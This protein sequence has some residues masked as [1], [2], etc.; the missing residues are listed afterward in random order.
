ML[1]VLSSLRR[2]A[3]MQ[4][5]EKRGCVWIVLA[6]G[7]LGNVS[8][9][10][11]PFTVVQATR[12]RAADITGNG[13]TLVLAAGN[14]GLWAVDADDPGSA[15]RRVGS[16]KATPLQVA[17]SR[18]QRP[19]VLTVART[20]RDTRLTSTDLES[21]KQEELP[22]RGSSGV[23]VLGRDAYVGLDDRATGAGRVARLR[24]GRA[25]PVS[26]D[27]PAVA[28]IGSARD[29]LLAC[30]PAIGAVS[31]IDPA[32]GTVTTGSVA[33]L[34][35]TL[36]AAQGLADGRILVLTSEVLAVADS[37]T[38]F[39]QRPF[40]VPPSGPLFVG[41]WTP[42]RFSLAGTGLGPDDVRLEVPDGPDAGLVSSA[43]ADQTSDPEPLLVAGGAVGRYPL[44]LVEAASGN[45]VADTAFEVTDHWYDEDTGPSR[46]ITGATAMEGGGGWGGGP[47][48]PQ[49][50]GDLTHTGTWNTLV[51]LVDT[52]TA[53][54]PTTPAATVTANQTTVLGHVVDG[55]TFNSQT[56]SA[57]HYYEENSGFVAASGGNPGRG[58]TIAARNNQVFGPVG[59]PD[60]WTTYFAQKKD[61]D[62][63]VI[64]ARWSS[65][66]TTIQTIISQALS[67][68]V[69][70]RADLTAVD[71]LII[72]PRSPD[73]DSA[74]GD[75]FV[76]PHASL[77]K[78]RLLLGTNVMTEQGDI[79]Y[80][81]VPL[82][83]AA[84]DGRQMHTTLSHEVGHNLGLLDVYDIEEYSADVT[85]RIT[86]DWEMMAGSR[87]RLPH[88]SLSNKMRMG[89]VPADQLRLYNFQGSGGVNDTITLHPAERADP[90]AGRVRGIE[91]RLG[92]GLNY[93]VEYRSEQSGLISDD[94]VTDRRVVVTDVTSEDY[95]APLA[96]PRIMFVAKDVDNDG[97]I[98][99]TG[100]DFED[101]DPGTQ[102]DLAVT[103]V[104]TAVDQ[105]SVRVTYGSQGKPEP[106]IRPWQGGPGWQSP[107]IEVRNDRATAEPA[108]W[109]NTPWLGHD[110]TIVAKVR[111][112]GDLIATGVVVDFFV[113]EY[114]TGDGP[115]VSLGF[116]RKDV[117]P[118][119]TVEFSRPWNPSSA[120]GRHYCVI[121]RIRL[122]QAP[123][124][125]AIV[126]QNIY[127]NEARSN[128]TSFISASASPST[129]VGTSVLL[130]NPFSRSTHVFAEV[131]QTHPQH[132]VFLEHQWLRVEGKGLRPVVVFDEAVWGTPEW[133]YVGEPGEKRP[134]FL[135]E[136]P[137]RV[138]IEGH[139]VRPYQTDCGS[140]IL[141]GGVGIQ[142]GAG[143]MTAV[144]IERRKLTYTTGFVRF[145]DDGS[146]VTSGTVL[147]EVSDG[148][149]SVTFDTPVGQDGRFGRD[150]DNPFGERTKWVQAHFLGTYSAAAS[151]SEQLE[152]ER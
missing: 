82:E 12:I 26:P 100:A 97:P 59:L 25:R 32:T 120:D 53:R 81:Y 118:G 34:P 94:L 11:G 54:W 24:A 105:A 16:V 99:G 129:R 93:Y 75:R 144:E 6:G 37:V 10:G 31:A 104:S 108:K 116:D 27:L 136:V 121:V 95:V 102:M 115:W 38:D 113:T 35:G 128:Y 143:R 52:S 70:T 107:D 148:Q 40:I 80:T 106:G 60:P 74:A 33:D 55:I 135:W 23:L 114:T 152:P 72:V 41:S 149:R 78:R 132:R 4:V 36:I 1:S 19:V 140:R 76:W 112:A 90:P 98:I 47:N 91:I 125:P 13:S 83:F 101:K 141:T 110:N 28:R 2:P 109:F 22:V 85:A 62:G 84:H 3:G 138:S 127:N 142:V 49:N 103:V 50:L 122:Y 117:G 63:N 30:H 119:A 17:A 137:N 7:A 48:T 18:R 58:L 123:G 133:R 21:G 126:D 124:N 87:D 43:R 66:G 68:G 45:V 130:A 151:E 146:A 64:D 145:V 71:A 79:A 86:S 134:G 96:R 46:M 8:L 88:Y 51:L 5:D 89:W 139:A 39:A 29:S 147:I 20:A 44:V 14:G 77:G 9:G 57:R 61:A 73:A 65:V 15:A 92:D 42:V 150:Y 131:E 69:V 67:A 111:N 56:R